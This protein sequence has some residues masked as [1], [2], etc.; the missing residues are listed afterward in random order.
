MNWLNV[1]M[2]LQM[3]NNQTLEI[4]WFLF[5]DKIGNLL[6]LTVKHCRNGQALSN[7]QLVLQIYFLPALAVC[8]FYFTIEFTFK[9]VQCITKSFS[10]LIQQ[11]KCYEYFDKRNVVAQWLSAICVQR[12][13]SDLSVVD[14]LEVT[15]DY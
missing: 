11:W 6:K 8:L 14:S 7:I 13:N 12:F 4:D 15:Q 9:N 1:T 3:A 5:L 10:Y 2:W